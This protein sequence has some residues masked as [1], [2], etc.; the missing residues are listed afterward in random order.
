MYKYNYGDV[1]KEWVVNRA[2]ENS[3]TKQNYHFARK[4]IKSYMDGNI[5]DV[6]M[7]V[8][9]HIRNYNDRALNFILNK[10]ERRG[11]KE[12]VENLRQSFRVFAEAGPYMMAVG[13][14]ESQGVVPVL[15]ELFAISMLINENSK[16]DVCIKE[17]ENTIIKSNLFPSNSILKFYNKWTTPEKLDRLNP[18]QVRQMLDDIV[19]NENAE[20]INNIFSQSKNLVGYSTIVGVVFSEVSNEGVFYSVIDKFYEYTSVYIDSWRKNILSNSNHVITDITLPVETHSI[21]M[22]TQ[23]HKINNIKKISTIDE[24]DK[25]NGYIN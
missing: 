15:G 8:E 3:T 18:G 4:I 25:F 24:F 20:D 6:R 16:K 10:L 9:F 23:K 13:M 1:I 22:E 11:T 21:F 2:M 17:L 19:F 12:D 5:E 14:D 7:L